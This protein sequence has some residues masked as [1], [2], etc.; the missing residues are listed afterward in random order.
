[1]NPFDRMIEIEKVIVLSHELATSNNLS[2]SVE[3][4]SEKVTLNK[5]ALD[6][7]H[8]LEK[9]TDAWRYG[10]ELF[11]H[12]ENEIVSFYA[13]GLLMTVLERDQ[14]F[15]SLENSDIDIILGTIFGW[16][17]VRPLFKR[18]GY[19]LNRVSGILVLLVKRQYPTKWPNAFEQLLNLASLYR[20][21]AT[22]F[23]T[24]LDYLN[25]DLLADSSTIDSNHH[26]RNTLIKD[27]MREGPIKD[28]VEFCLQV[29]NNFSKTDIDLVQRSL[30]TVSG[31]ISWIDINLVLNDRFL[32]ALYQFLLNE[33]QLEV[34]TL[35][36]FCAIMRKGMNIE[37]KIEIILRLKLCETLVN[38]IQSKSNSL[39]K[40]YEEHT[41][42]HLE[43]N[44]ED[45]GGSS[46]LEN[47]ATLLCDMGSELLYARL[48]VSSKSEIYVKSLQELFG[49]VLPLLLYK[50][51][52]SDD[53]NAQ[54]KINKSS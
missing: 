1:M 52:E 42:F 28:I 14:L 31:Y 48:N 46:F 6:F 13:L 37:S 27:S 53:H 47:I 54:K 41:T 4:N 21:A 34:Y 30:W 11:K 24:L 45:F 40:S 25:E 23:F 5:S 36:I 33:V 19:I 12:S 2:N 3:E 18:K 7:L 20:E 26:K 22:I 39:N 44:N 35:R 17:Q 51:L 15:F 43:R 32:D 29:M 16:L 50:C 8:E 38:V 10:V 9:S 49:K